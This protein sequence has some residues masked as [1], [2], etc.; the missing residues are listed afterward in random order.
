MEDLLK[1]LGR[2]VRELRA[3]KGW[4]QEEFAHVCGLHRTYIGQIERAE[5]NISF[6]NLTK[7]STAFGITMAE[8][9][10]GLEANGLAVPKL[11]NFRAASDSEILALEVQRFARRL[12]N[13]QAA[14]T[15]T[16][17][18]LVHVLS[19]DGT[20]DDSPKGHKVKPKR[21]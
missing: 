14:L 4:S 10:S 20:V 18:G 19:G 11:V 13:Q 17:A 3:A 9:V 7:L 6:E 12:S 16:V 8:L 1:K 15:K 5:K 2:R 21:K